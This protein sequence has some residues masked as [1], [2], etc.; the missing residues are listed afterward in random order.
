MLTPDT[1]R[2]AGEVL[3]GTRWQSDLARLVG[4]PQQHVAEWSTGKRAIPASVWPTISGALDER[5]A[6]IA[7]LAK[8]V[9]KAVDMSA[10]MV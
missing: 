1:L 9:R 10:S 6:T 7:R 3:F 8:K 2:E 5:S 4:R